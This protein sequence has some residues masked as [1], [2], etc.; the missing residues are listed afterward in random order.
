MNDIHVLDR[1]DG[2]Q[3]PYEILRDFHWSY[4]SWDSIIP[5]RCTVDGV[6]VRGFETDFG[7]YPSKPLKRLLEPRN[8][9][10]CQDYLPAPERTVW[11][12]EDNGAGPELV[13]WIEDEKAIGFVIHDFLYGVQVIP[14]AACDRVMY[15]EHVK[16]GADHPWIEFRAVRAFGWIPWSQAKPEDIREDRELAN[17]AYLRWET[18][19]FG[20]ESA[21][22]G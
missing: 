17:L 6:R 22:R 1:K 8:I 14:R 21:L 16:A 12:Y 13:G 5:G 18:A 20:E 3:W 10:P 7:S 2:T 15:E 9:V 19:R 4:G 11:V